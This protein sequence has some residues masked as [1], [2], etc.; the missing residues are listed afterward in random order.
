MPKLSASNGHVDL[1]KEL[2][3]P[4]RRLRGS[5]DPADYKR[6]VLPIIFLRFL[7]LRYDQRRAELERLLNDPDSEYYTEDASARSAVLDDGDEYRSKGA[8]VIP[9]DAR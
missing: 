7:S 8:F 4:A 5:I 2:W 6:Y 1:P 3:G 9:P